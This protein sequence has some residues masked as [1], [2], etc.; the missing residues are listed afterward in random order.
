MITTTPH[1]FMQ[2]FTTRHHGFIGLTGSLL[3]VR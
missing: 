1:A 2:P 3:R